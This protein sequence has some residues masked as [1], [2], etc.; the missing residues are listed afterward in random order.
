MAKFLFIEW[1]LTWLLEKQDHQFEWDSGNQTK[2]RS[3]HGIE[4][5]EIE[6]VFKSGLAVPLGVQISPKVSEE[7]LGIVGPTANGKLLHGVFTLRD[8]RVRPISGR[9]AHKK[10]RMKY[11]EILRKVSEGI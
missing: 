1:L 10:E 9:L 5:K 6:E 3:K 2:S 7:R 11:G 8:G 4:T